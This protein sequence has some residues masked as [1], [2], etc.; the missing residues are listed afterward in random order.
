MAT[1]TQT[2]AAVSGVVLLVLA[3]GQFLMTL[4]ASVM[5]VSIRQVAADLGTTVVACNGHHALHARHGL[6]HDHR[7]QD[8]SH[9]RP[10]PGFHR[11]PGYLRRRFGHDGDRPEPRV[12]LLGWSFLEGIGAALIM[13]AIVA[14]VA[15]NFAK[16][17]RSRAYGM[18]AAAGAIAVAVGPLI[19]G[20]V[21]TYASWRW[22]F[23]G[24]VASSWSS[25]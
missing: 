16:E 10:P 17:E 21:T 5:N 4:D 14:L 2:K 3:S 12:L 7:R 18:I 8:R 11:W 24:E 19:G 22:V 20:A 25:W 9:H 1:K 13:P 15:G 6:A 23:L